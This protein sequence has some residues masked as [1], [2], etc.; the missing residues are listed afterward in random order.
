MTKDQLVAKFS[1]MRQEGKADPRGRVSAMG[2]LFGIIFH[3]QIKHS[4][5]NAAAIA[6][7]AGLSD[8]DD[9]GIRDGQNLAEY[10]IVRDATRERFRGG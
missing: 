9:G 6:Q 3:R 10:V 2:H 5:T 8:G 4:D 1:E 7:E